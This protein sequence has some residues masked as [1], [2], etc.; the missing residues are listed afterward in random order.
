VES[1]P[2]I[3]VNISGLVLEN[4]GK[5]GVLDDFLKNLEASPYVE[6]AK[7]SEKFTREQRNDVWASKFTFPLRLKNPIS[8]K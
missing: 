7:E 4:D 2:V 3:N 1:G 6:P 5:Y 8:L